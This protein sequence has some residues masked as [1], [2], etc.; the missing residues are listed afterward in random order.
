MIYT[1]EQEKK[2]ESNF[3]Q[4]VD[5]IKENIQPYIPEGECICSYSDE[6]IHD[7]QISVSSDNIDGYVGRAHIH[8]DKEKKPSYCGES[9]Y[10]YTEWMLR[11]VLNWNQIKAGLGI[12]LEKKI[13][14]RQRIINAIENFEV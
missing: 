8:F 1:D 13:K 10:K 9:V 2:I 6:Q 12:D 3:G 4:I 11:I 7:C 14:E 5:Y